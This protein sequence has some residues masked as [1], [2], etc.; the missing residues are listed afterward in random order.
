MDEKKI[1][2][3]TDRELLE[4]IFYQNKRILKK[5]ESLLGEN[6]NARLAFNEDV[7]HWEDHFSSEIIEEKLLYKEYTCSELSEEEK[8]IYKKKLGRDPAEY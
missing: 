2:E 3:F 8:L 5:L 1:E 4:I 7:R 6:E